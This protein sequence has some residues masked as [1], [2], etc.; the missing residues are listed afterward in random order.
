M[1]KKKRIKSPLVTLNGI[2]TRNE[3]EIFAEE[4]AASESGLNKIQKQVL[5]TFS[6]HQE[7]P[8][9]RGTDFTSKGLG[10]IEKIVFKKNRK[11]AQTFLYYGSKEVPELFK[12]SKT[13]ATVKVPVSLTAYANPVEAQK[14]TGENGFVL[15][16]QEAVAIPVKSE[17]NPEALAYVIGPEAN[18][19]IEKIDRITWANKSLISKNVSVFTTTMK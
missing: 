6:S 11:T 9:E 2:D 5:S 7:I 17:E 15:I 19:E 8:E 18:L 13:G 4:L 14:H 12:K 1:A 16:V 3:E 10:V